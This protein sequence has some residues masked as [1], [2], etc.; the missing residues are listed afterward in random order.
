[1]HKRPSRWPHS[2]QSPSSA[3]GWSSAWSVTALSIS[4][5]MRPAPLSLPGDSGRCPGPEFLLGAVRVSAL[6]HDPGGV[7]PGAPGA[8]HARLGGLSTPSLA[9]L[10]PRWSRPEA[11]G[12]A[13]DPGRCRR[14]R[15]HQGSLRAHLGGLVMIDYA[16]CCQIQHPISSRDSAPRSLPPPCPSIRAPSPTGSPRSA[17]GPGKRVHGPVNSIRSRRRLAGCSTRIRIPPPRSGSGCASTALRGATPWSKPTCAPSDPSV[18][19]PF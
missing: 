3:A 2:A 12:C 5:A 9:G 13:R 11:C 15:R 4:S 10:R 14:I 17:S 7:A 16:C 1:M 6:V 19:P 8:H 18:R